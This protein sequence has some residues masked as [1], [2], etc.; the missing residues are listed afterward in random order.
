MQQA[1]STDF[2][3][4]LNRH[5]IAVREEIVADLKIRLKFPDRYL[6]LWIFL[7]MATGVSWDGYSPE[8]QD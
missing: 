1:S 7:A 3:A 5:V 2:Y 4:E 6:T 8:L